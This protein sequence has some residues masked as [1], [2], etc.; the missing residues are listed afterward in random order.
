MIT[1]HHSLATKEHAKDPRFRN[2]RRQIFHSS[3]SKI[4]ATLKPAMTTPEIVRFGDGHYR[5]VI[6]G[7]GPYIAD[8]EEQALLTCIVRG[9]C[10][11]YVL[12]FGISPSVSHS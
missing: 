8:Y 6:Y 10:P 3:L 7:L 12:F 9:W 11:K 1:A 2:F 4:L 5:P